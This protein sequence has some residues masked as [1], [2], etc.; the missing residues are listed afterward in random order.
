VRENTE[1]YWRYQRYSFVREYFERP[2]LAYPPLIIFSHI[3]LIVRALHRKCCPTLCHNQVGDINQT[4]R[5]Q[6]LTRIFSKIDN[7]IS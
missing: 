4:S 1:F 5:L 3:V 7:F 2:P 6:S